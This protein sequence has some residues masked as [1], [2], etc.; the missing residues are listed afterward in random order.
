MTRAVSSIL[1]NGA[2]G[3]IQKEPRPTKRP[4]AFSTRADMAAVARRRIHSLQRELHAE[5]WQ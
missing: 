5:A 1:A 3:I 4:S 2:L